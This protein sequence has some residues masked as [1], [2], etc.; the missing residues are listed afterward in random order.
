MKGPKPIK[1]WRYNPITG[2]WDYERDCDD[3]TADQWLTVFQKDDPE[4][5]FKLSKMK[6][7]T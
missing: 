6:P 1:L 4:G 2:Y 3:D 5:L 7:R